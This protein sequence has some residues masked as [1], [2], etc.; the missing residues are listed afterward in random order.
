MTCQ[1]H[2]LKL[3]RMM[4]M[5]DVMHSNKSECSKYEGKYTDYNFFHLRI[6][7]SAEYTF[8]SIKMWC[9]YVPMNTKATSNE[10]MKCCLWK[11]MTE[12]L[13]LQNIFTAEQKIMVHTLECSSL[14]IKKS[15]INH[16]E[17]EICISDPR[18]KTVKASMFLLHYRR[19]NRTKNV[20]TKY[21]VKEI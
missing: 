13:P 12:Q 1:K 14:N 6:E 3:Y 4:H 8:I 18:F 21:V 9:A 19:Y 2:W 20:Q 10:F 16:Y 11:C 17:I 5:Q 7:Y 15:F